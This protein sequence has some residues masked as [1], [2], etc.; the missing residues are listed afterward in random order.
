MQSRGKLRNPN[1]W[2]ALAEGPAA[3]TGLPPARAHAQLE[4]H[5]GR[6]G[7][8]A[9]LPRAVIDKAVRGASH[10]WSLPLPMDYLGH[11]CPSGG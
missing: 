8:L 4:R 11:S 10:G 2:A 3:A 1:R 6:A 7:V 9:P 5:F